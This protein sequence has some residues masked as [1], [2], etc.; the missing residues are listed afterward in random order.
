MEI[1][2]RTAAITMSWRFGW[3]SNKTRQIANST[4]PGGGLALRASFSPLG[5]Y[6]SGRSVE[7]VKHP[8]HNHSGHRHVE[9]KRERPAGNSHVLLKLFGPSMVDR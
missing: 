1:L 6:L 5:P 3:R 9:P 7:V 4:A 8:V 2:C